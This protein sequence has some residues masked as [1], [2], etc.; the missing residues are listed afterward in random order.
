MAGSTVAQSRRI[1]GVDSSEAALV[2]AFRLGLARSPLRSDASRRT[3]LQFYEFDGLSGRADVVVARV[4]A[5][6]RRRPAHSVLSNKTACRL[7]LALERSRTPLSANDLAVRL[8]L[9]APTVRRWLAELRRTKVVVYN[10]G[11]FTVRWDTTRLPAVDLWSFEAKLTN[12]Q[13]ALYQATRYKAY[14]SKVFVVMPTNRARAAM[15]HIDRFRRANVG[16]IT[17]DESCK[18]QIKRMPRREPP[19]SPSLYRMATALIAQTL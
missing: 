10:A 11:R 7:V 15:K 17:V 19:Y 13:R 18:I 14:S 12:W 5:R 3:I 9:S 8:G 1:R 16:L 2:K 6:L 4:P